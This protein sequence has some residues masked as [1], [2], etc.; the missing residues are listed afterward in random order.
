MS[1]II[2]ITLVIILSIICFFCLSLLI[3]QKL[4]KGRD[5]VLST[6]ADS[7]PNTV[8][9]ISVVLN[10]CLLNEIKFVLG[11]LTHVLGFLFLTTVRCRAYRMLTNWTFHSSYPF[12]HLCNS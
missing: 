7:V 10:K 2:Y 3:D 11:K 8:L 9:S 5:C 4:Q 6:I 1:F 12:W